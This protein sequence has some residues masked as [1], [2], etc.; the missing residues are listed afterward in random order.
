MLRDC[1]RDSSQAMEL[2][3]APH[4]DE[5][6][7]LVQRGHVGQH[8]GE[9]G[10]Y[11][12]VRVGVDEGDA[13]DA[14][15]ALPVAQLHAP[16]RSLLPG[17]GRQRARLAPARVAR[18]VR[19][20]SLKACVCHHPG[21]VRSLKLKSSPQGVTGLTASTGGPGSTSWPAGQPVKVVGSSVQCKLR[22]AKGQAEHR[23][24]VMRASTAR[25]SWDIVRGAAAARTRRRR[26]A[27]P[28]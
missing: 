25:A 28:A 2:D 18:P 20:T 13:G 22:R 16:Q 7:D 8:V 11:P 4:G 17:L 24:V 1:V 23:L 19:W 21:C 5:D 12:R 10:G 26:R 14:R 27:A 15:Q 3:R 6:D 9:R